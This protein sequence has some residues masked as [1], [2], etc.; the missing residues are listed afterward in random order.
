MRITVRLVRSQQ[1]LSPSS[2]RL[3]V[4][5][6]G[7]GVPILLYQYGPYRAVTRVQRPPLSWWLLTAYSKEGVFIPTTDPVTAR[8][9]QA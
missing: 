4:A 3:A 6:T 9:L 7:P 2:L 8:V 1:T 5:F